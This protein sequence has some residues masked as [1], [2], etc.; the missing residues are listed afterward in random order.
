MA[1]RTGG[2]RVPHFAADGHCSGSAMVPVVTVTQAMAGP[3]WGV[4]T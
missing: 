3:T 2:K 4:V 1:F